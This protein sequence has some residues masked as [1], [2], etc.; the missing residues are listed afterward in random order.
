MNKIHKRRF[1]HLSLFILGLIVAT[2]L[3]LYALKQNMNV[4]MTPSQL[5]TTHFRTENNFRLGGMVK[6]GSLS[7]DKK[8][9][10]LEFIVT[11]LKHEIRVRYK[12]V[13]PYLFREGTGV[14][15][16]GNLNQQG[17]FIANIILAK[18]DEKY[19]PRDYF[20]SDTKRNIK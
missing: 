10:G 20:L 15:A 7:H 4:F 5:A 17:L 18:H 6:K 12:G 19:M 13:L 14:I 8:G 1:L 3:I 11:D 2:S 16:E 9:L